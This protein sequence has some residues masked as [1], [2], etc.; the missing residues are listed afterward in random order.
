MQ[1][2]LHTAFTF[3]NESMLDKSNLGQID[4]PPGQLI[5]FLQKGLLYREMESHLA[6]VCD[7]YELH[8]ANHNHSPVGSILTTIGLERMD[9]RFDA[10]LHSRW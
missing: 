6:D 9:R 2:F 8:Q 1:G 4:T 5:S 7:R 3:Y 10:Q